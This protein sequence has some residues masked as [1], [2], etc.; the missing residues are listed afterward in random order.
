MVRNARQE[1][2]VR[3]RLDN[4]CNSSRNHAVSN[5]GS[6][7]LCPSRVGEMMGRDD[8]QCYLDQDLDENGNVWGK[9]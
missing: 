6:F 7:K 4:C 8:A 2:H 1:W 9:D 5:I 3:F